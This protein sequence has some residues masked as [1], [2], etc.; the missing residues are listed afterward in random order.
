MNRQAQR[1][2]CQVQ[3]RPQ[4][5]IGLQTI[6]I[7]HDDK[8]AIPQGPCL[9]ATLSF[10]Q[11]RGYGLYFVLSRISCEA[12]QRR[13]R[14]FE[15]PDQVFPRSILRVTVHCTRGVVSH[16]RF[17]AASRSQH[18]KTEV[19]GEISSIRRGD[20]VAFKNCMKIAFRRM[21]IVSMEDAQ[22]ISELSNKRRD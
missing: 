5:E 13:R 21:N 8:D 14:G 22:L 7:Q 2:T 11:P 1:P 15:N 20:R 9:G 4:L 17:P 3:D 18:Q 19:A 12:V 6:S 10:K 16:L